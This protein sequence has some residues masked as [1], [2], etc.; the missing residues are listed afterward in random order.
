[1]IPCGVSGKT[2]RIASTRRPS[3]TVAVPIVSAMIETGSATPIA[4]AICSS[5]L[6]ASP[7]A[8]TFFATWRA[9]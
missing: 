9:M 7:A 4:Y 5:T 2:S 8:T 6:D 3:S 1:M